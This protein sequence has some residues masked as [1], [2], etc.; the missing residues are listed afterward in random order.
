MIRPSADQYFAQMASLVATRGTCARRKVGCVLVDERNHVL[1][2][3]YNGP[4]RGFPHCIDVPC[5]GA[6]Q[7]SGQGLELCQ[8]VHAEQNALLQ[9]KDVYA[10]KTVYCTTAPCV[11]CVKLLLNTSCDRVVFTN[12]YPHSEASRKL[13]AM[14]PKS[15][16]W[17]HIGHEVDYVAV[18]EY[19]SEFVVCTCYDQGII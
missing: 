9:C 10:I 11:H 17:V 5:E 8:A 14:G 2:T 18:D 19:S 3:G 1:A 15:R 6:S 7:P 16:E 12:D 13:W 4:P